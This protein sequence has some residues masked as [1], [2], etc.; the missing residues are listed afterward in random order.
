MAVVGSMIAEEQFQYG[1][2]LDDDEHAAVDH[3]V[4]IGTQDIDDLDGALHLDA[5]GDID[6]QTVLR[7]HGVEGGDGIAV[8]MGE[9]GIMVG[10]QLRMLCCHPAE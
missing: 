10:H 9:T 3:Q 8:S 1:S 7:E 2:L 5:F 6:E 4:D